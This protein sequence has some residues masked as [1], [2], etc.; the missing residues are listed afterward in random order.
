[1]T[2]VIN[3]LYALAEVHQVSLSSAPIL[4]AGHLTVNVMRQFNNACRHYFSMKDV[5]TNN[6]VGKIIYNFKS[7]SVQLWIMA[8]EA[9][10]IA[11]P[12]PDFLVRLKKKFLPQTWEDD[13]VQDQIAIQGS[14]N[15]LTWVNKVHN[16][17]DKL[18][19]AQLPYHIPKDHFCLH[20]LPH[21]SN[22]LKC[23]YKANNGIAP[24]ATKGTL[25]TITDF[26]DWLEHL[27]L[28]ELDLQ[29]VHSA[30]S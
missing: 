24:G 23:L 13:L 2:P 4:S 9:Q 30:M 27:H 10:L 5:A 12:F 17:N 11:L 25:D 8:E 14:L 29:A 1:M 18:K 15:L 21:L 22:G 26:N 20:L 28:L 16:A 19:A 6:H 7:T 3:P